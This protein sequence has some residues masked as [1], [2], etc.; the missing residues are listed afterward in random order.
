MA[1]ALKAAGV[2]PAVVSKAGA[3]KQAVSCRAGKY[4]AELIATAVRWTGGGSVG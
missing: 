3:R 1:F 4:D 2:S